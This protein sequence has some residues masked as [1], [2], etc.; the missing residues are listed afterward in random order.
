M[1]ELT[2]N[3]CP[4]SEAVKEEGRGVLWEKTRQAILYAYTNLLADYDFFMKADDDSYVIVENLRFILSKYSPD[5][6]FLMGRRFGVS[7]I[8]YLF[9]MKE[10][11]FIL[12]R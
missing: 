9:L 1:G 3:F 7:W 11:C 10:Q 6:P 4:V 8:R 5:E 12:L 2:V